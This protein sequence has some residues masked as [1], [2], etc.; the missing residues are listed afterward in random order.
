MSDLNH[1]IP[2]THAEYNNWLRNLEE[3][4]ALRLYEAEQ[5]KLM[6]PMARPRA[7]VGI[8]PYLSNAA[9]LWLDGEL[10]KTYFGE[11][12]WNDA[13]RDANAINIGNAK[14]DPFNKNIL[15][16]L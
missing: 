12:C 4:L 14:I 6:P 5:P 1:S 7:A 11:D 15:P 3:R 10:F 13:R 2:Y 8:S 16:D 9:A